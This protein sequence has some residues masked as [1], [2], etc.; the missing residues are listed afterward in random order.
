MPK[1]KNKYPKSSMSSRNLCLF[2]ILSFFALGVSAQSRPAIKWVRVEGGSFMMGCRNGE[3]GCYPD[4]TEHLVELS[5]FE[6]SAY[7]ITVE[8]YRY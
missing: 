8:Q 1:T 2:V 5:G 4:E 3:K 6:I 7:E